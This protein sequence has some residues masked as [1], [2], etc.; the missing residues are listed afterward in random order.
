[1]PGKPTKKYFKNPR[2]VRTN[3]VIRDREGIH[4]RGILLLFKIELQGD[5]FP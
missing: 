2:I 4:G 1:V 3:L 5:F